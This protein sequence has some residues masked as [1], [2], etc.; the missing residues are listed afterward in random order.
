MGETSDSLEQELIT[1]SNPFLT[2]VGELAKETNESESSMK[3]AKKDS[4]SFHYVISPD[5]L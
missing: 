2:A 4:I 5:T 1:D 3:Q